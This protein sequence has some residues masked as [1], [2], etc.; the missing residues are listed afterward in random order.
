MLRAGDFIFV[1]LQDRMRNRG[2][3]LAV[4]SVDEESGVGVAPMAELFS[5]VG[6]RR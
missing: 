4:E 1:N 3:I 6:G 2:G 5:G